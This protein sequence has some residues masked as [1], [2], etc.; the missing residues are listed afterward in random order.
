LGFKNSSFFCCS[1]P[2]LWLRSNAIGSNAPIF[3]AGLWWNW[4]ARNIVCVGNESIHSFKVVAEVNKLAALIVSCFPARVVT[5]TRRRWISWHPC[6][7]DCVVLNVDGSCL[8]DP[9]RAGFGG[10]FRYGDGEWIS[11][12]SGYLGI[13]NNTFAELMALYHGLK[14]AREAGNNRLFCYS[15]SK[16][17]L[18]LLSTDMNSFHCYA[19]TIANIQDLLKLEWDVSVRHSLREGNFCADFLATLGSANEA[20]LSI[21]ESPPSNM[22][23]LLLSDALRV[24]YP[25]A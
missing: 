21:W 3:L 15:D 20:K 22:Q 19:A 9:G 18:D 5:D 14:I 23:N 13:A 6:K 24:P 12:F 10:L 2:E 17:V 16:T 11:G 1:D 8:G 25:R 4:W 7:T